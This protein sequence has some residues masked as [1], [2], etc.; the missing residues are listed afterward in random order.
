MLLYNNRKAHLFSLSDVPIYNSILI[1]LQAPPVTVYKPLFFYVSSTILM[2]A[3]ILRAFR[4]L[5]RLWQFGQPVRTLNL[6][7]VTVLCQNRLPYIRSGKIICKQFV[8]HCR[9]GVKNIPFRN[10]FVIKSRRRCNREIIALIAIPFGVNPVQ[11]KRHD[12]QYICP[13]RI[14]RPSCIDF[15]GSNIFD[16][17]FIF[18]II[19]LCGRIAW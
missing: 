15:T 10:P 18:Y 16:I 19:I 7:S 9:N 5:Y 6:P 2:T 4:L 14:F 17:I 13:D 8:H 1:L 3:Y 11:R 12:C